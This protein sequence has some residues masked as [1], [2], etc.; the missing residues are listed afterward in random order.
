MKA[1]ALSNKF[2]DFVER[3][4]KDVERALNDEYDVLADYSLHD[5]TMT[6]TMRDMRALEVARVE[7]SRRLHNSSMKDGVGGV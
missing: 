4:S 2:L 6:M 7:S 1:L 3:S 5:A